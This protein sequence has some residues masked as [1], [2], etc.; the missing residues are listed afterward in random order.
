MAS[1]TEWAWAYPSGQ[2]RMS[3]SHSFIAVER[4]DARSVYGT[5]IGGGGHPRLRSKLGRGEGGPALASRGSVA[6]AHA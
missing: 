2:G 4:I 1:L 6:S 5:Q 3:S